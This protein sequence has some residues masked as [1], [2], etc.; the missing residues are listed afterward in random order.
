MNHIS[1]ASAPTDPFKGS[2][3]FSI[4]I[5]KYLIVLLGR[6]KTASLNRQKEKLLSHHIL[7]HS[8]TFTYFVKAN[9]FS[10]ATGSI[11]M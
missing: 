4:Y 1:S 9:Q 3:V 5:P 10:E 2:L 7:Y 11:P 8:Q 6:E